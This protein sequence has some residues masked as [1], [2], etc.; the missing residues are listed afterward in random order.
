MR[1]KFDEKIKEEIKKIV[2]AE[3]LKFIVL[4]ELRRVLETFPL[5]KKETGLLI[6]KLLD[7]LE[8]CEEK[9]KYQ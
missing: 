9:S 5:H 3:M 1:K 7:L 6:E 2:R 4:L 8:E